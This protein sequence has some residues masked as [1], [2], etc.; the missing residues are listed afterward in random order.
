MLQRMLVLLR[1]ILMKVVGEQN[2]HFT[3]LSPWPMQKVKRAASSIAQEIIWGAWVVVSYSGYW[4]IV[5]Y[6]PCVFAPC[7]Y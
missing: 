4:L 5:R 3:T 1:P 2:T 7:L 6:Y